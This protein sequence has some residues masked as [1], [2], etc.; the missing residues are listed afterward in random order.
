VNIHNK[1]FKKGK[2]STTTV[3]QYG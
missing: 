3:I 2:T 1:I